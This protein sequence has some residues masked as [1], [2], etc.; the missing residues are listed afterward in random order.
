MLLMAFEAAAREQPN[1][2][3]LAMPLT[4][5]LVA[6]LLPCF[7]AKVFVLTEVW[8]GT[9]IALSLCAYG[10]NLRFL[11]ATMALAALFFRELALPYCLLGLALALWQ[12]RPKES[13]VYV[14]G[15]IGWAVFY[16]LHC[17]KV[18][19]LITATAV[20]HRHGWVQFGGLT[21]VIARAQM[22]SWLVLL[23][24]WVTVLFFAL[25]MIGLAGWQTAWGTRIAL[26]ACMY[27]VAFSVVGQEFN[28]YWGLMIA[29]LFCF[30]VVRAPAALGDLWRAAK[31]PLWQELAYF[32]Q[33]RQFRS[34]GENKP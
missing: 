12:R 20:A 26:T 32:G 6:P 5:L 21:F 31:L 22:N 15:L 24:V 29:P 23:P 13:I 1:V 9:M 25:A 10:V 19:Q 3:R 33:F 34:V 27:V 4:V 30:G 14:V 17:W 11:G 28:R 18:S 8:A 16:A 7:Q 2:Y